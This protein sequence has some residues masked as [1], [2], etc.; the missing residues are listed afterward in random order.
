[1]FVL[2]LKEALI[3]ERP[4]RG[5]EETKAGRMG[6]LASADGPMEIGWNARFALIS[7]CCVCLAV[8]RL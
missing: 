6:R 5:T 4:F 8:K 2:V 3:G 7:E 1:M